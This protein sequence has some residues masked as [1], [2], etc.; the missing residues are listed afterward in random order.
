VF[1]SS[2]DGPDK[3][4]HEA[5]VVDAAAAAGIVLVVK[6]STLGADP[7][8]SLPPFAWNGRSEAHLRRSGI[9]AV[10]LRSSFYMTNLL[11]AAEQVRREGILIAPAGTGPTAMIDPHDVGEVAA[12]V[13]TGDGHAGRTYGLTGP[14]AIGYER[15]ARELSDA[16]GAPVRYV[17][18]PEEAVR[19]G[20]G[21]SGMPDWLVQHLVGMFRLVRSGAMGDVT[22]T[23]RALTGHAPRTFVDFARRHADAFRARPSQPVAAA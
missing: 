8:S 13:L 1:V 11:A 22:D 17:D 18:A 5:A 6:A 7:G 21:A 4:A 19:A 14:E 20:L 15:V 10:V 12:T 9:P 23:V 16:V 3:V 2:A